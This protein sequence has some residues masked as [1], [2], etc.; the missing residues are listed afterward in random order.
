[1]LVRC[2]FVEYFRQAL[3]LLAAQ[4]SQPAMLKPGHIIPDLLPFAI[5]LTG[6]IQG[7]VTLIASGYSLSLAFPL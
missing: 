4:S 1:M 2:V 7:P 5:N 6:F 3:A